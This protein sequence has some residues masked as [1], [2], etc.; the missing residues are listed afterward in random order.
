LKLLGIPKPPTGFP[1]SN[2]CQLSPWPGSYI[3]IMMPANA[4]REQLPKT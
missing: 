4:L 3:A 2:P 1:L